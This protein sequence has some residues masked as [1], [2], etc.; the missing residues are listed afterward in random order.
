M[1]RINMSTN[2]KNREKPVLRNIIKAQTIPQRT[3]LA[4]ETRIDSSVLREI[5]DEINDEIQDL[6]CIVAERNIPYIRI[7]QSIEHFN[8]DKTRVFLR[9]EMTDSQ[10]LIDL[11]R[12]YENN[13]ENTFLVEL[14]LN[15]NGYVEIGY[16][17]EFEITTTKVSNGILID[18]DY[19]SCAL[20]DIFVDSAIFNSYSFLRTLS[21]EEKRNFNKLKVDFLR[22]KYKDFTTLESSFYVFNNKNYKYLSMAFFARQ[23]KEVIDLD[24]V[25]ALWDELISQEFKNAVHI[26][27]PV[28][29]Q[30]KAL[31]DYDQ[32]TDKIKND[33]L[34]L[35]KGAYWL[36]RIHRKPNA[37]KVKQ[38]TAHFGS[39]ELGN[40]RIINFENFA[41][42]EK[43][44]KEQD[45]T[46][47]KL[48]VS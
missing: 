13:P 48:I 20:V 8:I 26:E 23:S 43:L 41:A 3:L 38:L 5:V 28:G 25:I 6:N 46:A 2:R 21:N 40:E 42:V 16:A 33:C 44:V 7:E 34:K 12:A 47:F 29:N 36:L 31:Q 18:S 39:A 17:D 24:L 9:T 22:S 10:S 1:R 14:F 27:P 15:H 32:Y 19:L 4:F 30:L 11:E 35:S 45:I 37:N